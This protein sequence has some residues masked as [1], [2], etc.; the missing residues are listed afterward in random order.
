MFGLTFHQ[1]GDMKTM[2]KAN[3]SLQSVPSKAHLQTLLH[4]SPSPVRVATNH[5]VIHVVWLQREHPHP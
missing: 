3:V 4:M 5:L 2:T 1:H